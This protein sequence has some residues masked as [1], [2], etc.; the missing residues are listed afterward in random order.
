M[1]ELAGARQTRG[2]PPAPLGGR[3]VPHTPLAAEAAGEW[4]DVVAILKPVDPA[5]RESTA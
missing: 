5:L 1:S 4:D 2:E 3:P